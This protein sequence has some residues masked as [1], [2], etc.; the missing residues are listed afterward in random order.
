MENPPP[1]IPVKTVPLWQRL[2]VGRNPKRTMVRVAILAVSSF[3]VFKFVLLPARI[4][5]E[6][7]EP[8]YRDGRVNFIN[9]LA[10]RWKKPRRGDVVGVMMAGKHMML[11]KRIIALPG[12]TVA[13]EQGTVL[14]NGQPLDEPYV[15]ERAPW[16]LSPRPLGSNEYLL[17]G[18]NRGMPQETH[19]FGV[20]NANRFVGKI[21][22]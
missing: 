14:I 17:I 11:L 4:C 16:Q 5:G 1:A 19:D 13:I 20:A 3:I 9:Q 8:T 6:S 2:L 15:K 7:M 22:W 21:L 12:E 10:Y 18:D